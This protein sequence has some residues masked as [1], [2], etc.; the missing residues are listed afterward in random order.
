MHSAYDKS[1]L[2]RTRN[3]PWFNR[4]QIK[5]HIN[6]FLCDRAVFVP[7][8]FVFVFRKLADLF[9]TRYESIL[10]HY[11]NALRLVRG[12]CYSVWARERVQRSEWRSE[13]WNLPIVCLVQGLLPNIGQQPVDGGRFTSYSLTPITTLFSLVQTTWNNKLPSV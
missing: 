8:V 9:V 11:F 3:Q 10:S 12:I 13:I 7:L 6:D 2:S 1:V 5:C 4:T